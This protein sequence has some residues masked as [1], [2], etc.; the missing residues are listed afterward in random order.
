MIKI[1]LNKAKDITH[2]IRR[3][4]RDE[5]FKPLDAKATIPMYSESVELERQKIRDEFAEIQEKIECAESTEDLK[6]LIE[7]CRCKC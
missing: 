2:N 1:D 3:E 7:Q 5:L 6:N 4:V